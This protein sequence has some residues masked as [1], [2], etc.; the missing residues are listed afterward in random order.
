[1]DFFTICETLAQ[2]MLAY[3]GKYL[4]D[5]KFQAS[6]QN[7]KSKQSRTRSPVPPT[8]AT[9]QSHITTMKAGV[10][11]NVLNEEFYKG[12]LCGFLDDG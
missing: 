7:P 6:T 11:E 4:G 3:S 9:T 2:Q 8:V 1:M 12:Q 10:T 5:D